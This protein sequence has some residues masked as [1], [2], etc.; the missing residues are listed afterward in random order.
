MS[1]DTWWAKALV[2]AVGAVVG[3][4]LSGLVR[5]SSPAWWEYAVAALGAAI[6]GSVVFVL[7][8]RRTQN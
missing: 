6:G 8:N 1:F 2:F 3:V 7:V 5:D 4:F